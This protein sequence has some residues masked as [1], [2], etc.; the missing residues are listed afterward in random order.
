M[1]S[2]SFLTERGI[3]YL[4]DDH[5]GANRAAIQQSRLE[6]ARQVC[7]EGI[8]LGDVRYVGSPDL[9]DS[10][11]QRA[12]CYIVEIR[13]CMRANDLVGAREVLGRAYPFGLVRQAGL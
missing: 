5:A 4:S 12:A 1:G 7:R 6:L 8:L 9:D 3:M 13:K 10:G 2:G 11:L